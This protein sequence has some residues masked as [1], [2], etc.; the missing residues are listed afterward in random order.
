ML[1]GD[2]VEHFVG[3]GPRALNQLTRFSGEQQAFDAHNN[4]RVS[5]YQYC[6]PSVQ[7]CQTVLHEELRYHRVELL[8]RAGREKCD[9]PEGQETWLCCTS[10][11][12]LVVP[13]V[14]YNSSGS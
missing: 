1:V 5:G 2:R 3:N 4:P 10:F 8:D 7:Y 11:G 14:K 12:R 6:G 9:L 13:E